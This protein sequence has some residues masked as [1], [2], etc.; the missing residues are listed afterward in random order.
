[1]S[2]YDIRGRTSSSGTGGTGITLRYSYTEW[3]TYF[4][5]V[6]LVCTY[7]ILYVTNQSN[8][9]CLIQIPSFSFIW[10]GQR[11]VCTNSI[12]S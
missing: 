3:M 9:F 6:C 4:Y 1:M 10:K 5:C 11:D 12:P 8:D 2:L 7:C